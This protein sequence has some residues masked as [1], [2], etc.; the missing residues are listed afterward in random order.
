MRLII[1]IGNRARGDDAAGLVVAERL[2]LSE[3]VIAHNGEAASLMQLW[4][5]ATEVVLVDAVTAGL[6]AGSV[7]EVDVGRQPIPTGL[8]RSTHALGPAE[9]LELSRVL[10]ALPDVVTLYGIEGADFSPGGG[11]SPEVE[12]AV[13]RVVGELRGI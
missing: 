12:S 4:S 9:A 11:L 3:R 7:V 5:Q 6:P 8:C 2:G 13:D 10:G 1:G